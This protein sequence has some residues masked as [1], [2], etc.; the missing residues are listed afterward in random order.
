MFVSVVVCVFDV[1][2]THTR[3]GRCWRKA[4][5]QPTPQWGLIGEKTKGPE[6]GHC[7]VSPRLAIIHHNIDGR[8]E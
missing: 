6:F 1:C 3:V 4:T 8:H 5:P 2:K 7:R